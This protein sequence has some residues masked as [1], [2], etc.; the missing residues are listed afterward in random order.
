MCPK[1]KRDESCVDD[2]DDDDD[3]DDGL[4]NFTLQWCALTADA[5]RD[6]SSPSGN[7]D[8]ELDDDARAR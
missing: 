3:D 4:F 6:A 2:D 1:L 7:F 8:S 5:V